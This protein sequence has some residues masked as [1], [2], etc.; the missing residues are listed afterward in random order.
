MVA[1]PTSTTRPYRRRKIIGQFAPRLIEMLE[2][3]AFRVLSL[4]SH[5]ILDRIEIELAHHAGYDNGKLPV[6]YGDFVRYGIERHS[7]APA[8]RELA[9]LGFVEV[10]ERGR[11]GNAE[12]RTPNKFRLTYRPTDSAGATDEWRKVSTVE[13]AKLIAQMARN[14]RKRSNLPNGVVKNK[15]QCGKIPA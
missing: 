12:H 3:A 8:Q 14:P 4:S 11:A 10:T 13:D 1:P 7:I 2:S 6:T 5:R 15:N 9:A